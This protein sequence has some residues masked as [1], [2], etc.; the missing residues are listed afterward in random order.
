MILKSTDEAINEI[1]SRIKPYVGV[2]PQSTFSSTLTR[3]ET[4]KCRYE[5]LITF[6]GKFGYDLDVVSWK[7]ND[8]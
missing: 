6:M 2:M 5:T 4:G 7:K 8:E 3:I 1:K